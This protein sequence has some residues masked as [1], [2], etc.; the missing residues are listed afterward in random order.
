MSPTVSVAT[1]APRAAPRR[2]AS[3]LPDSLQEVAGRAWAASGVPNRSKWHSGCEYMVRVMPGLL[4]VATAET[5]R[6]KFRNTGGSV[7]SPGGRK[8]RLTAWLH[9]SCCGT[10]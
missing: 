7:K 1:A 5:N 9:V 8:P 3:C 4:L 10:G 2:R 6:S